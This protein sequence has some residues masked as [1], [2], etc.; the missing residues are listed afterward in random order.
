MRAVL[1]KTG[2]LAA[3]V[4]LLVALVAVLVVAACAPTT[5][6]GI[7]D[8]ALNRMERTAEILFHRMEL[9]FLESGVYTTN[10]LIDAPLPEGA[11][12]TLQDFAPDGSSYVLFLTSTNLPDLAWHISPRGVSRTANR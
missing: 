1:A 10:V 2:N 11:R 12:W 6:P 3:R 7:D 8:A 5:L 4:P 9:G